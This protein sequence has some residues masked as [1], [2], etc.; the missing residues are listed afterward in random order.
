[1]LKLGNIKC[2][3]N[4]SLQ[5]DSGGRYKKYELKKAKI[6]NIAIQEEDEQPAIQPFM[7]IEK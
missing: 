3:S 7:Q 2:S 5:K 4:K 6:L 1:M